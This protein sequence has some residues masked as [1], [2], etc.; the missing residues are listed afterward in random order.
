MRTSHV[1][2]A[3]CA[4]GMLQLAS[5]TM[6][7]AQHVAS[8]AANT[9]MTSARPG[10]GTADASSCVRARPGQMPEE[11]RNS[12]RCN[13]N[14]WIEMDGWVLVMWRADGGR[15][16]KHATRRRKYMMGGSGRRT[17]IARRKT[18]PASDKRAPVVHAAEP[19]ASQAESQSNE[20]QRDESTRRSQSTASTGTTERN[21]LSNSIVHALEKRGINS[22]G[23]VLSSDESVKQKHN[24][25]PAVILPPARAAGLPTLPGSAG[26]EA[27]SVRTTDERRPA[28]SPIKL[29][30]NSSHLTALV[31]PSIRSPGNARRLS[32]AKIIRAHRNSH[33]VDSLYCRVELLWLLWLLELLWRLL[34]A[35]YDGDRRRESSRS[36][37]IGTELRGQA[38]YGENR[39]QTWRKRRSFGDW[40]ST[41]CEGNNSA[42]DWSCTIS[43]MVEYLELSDLEVSRCI[44]IP[45]SRAAVDDLRIAAR[46]PVGLG[47]RLKDDSW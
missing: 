17:E 26:L 22:S 29:I 10:R 19:R 45:P 8:A 5:S 35:Q 28:E 30:D 16:V 39:Q 34:L 44:S 13:R 25:A 24:A 41:S 1:L 46:E 15:K 43:V 38:L 18:S 11:T 2:Q 37:E 9:S 3:W 6:S 36:S 21:A 31:T 47:P 12:R 7:A 23:N 20:H 33:S 42:D 4:A 40:S 14:R 32:A 27:G